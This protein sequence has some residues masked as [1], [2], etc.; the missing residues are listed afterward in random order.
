MTSLKTANRRV[1]SFF[2][3]AALLLATITPGLVPAFASAAQV[4]ERSVELSSASKSNPGTQYKV[5]FTAAASAGAVVVDFCSNSPL[6]GFTCDHPAGFVTGSATTATSGFTL[7]QTTASG[8]DAV[9]LTGAISGATEF[10]VDNITNPSTP[11]SLYVR[12]VTYD[13]EAHAQDYTATNVND[14]GSGAIDQGSAAVSITDTIG[15]SASV[16]ETMTFCVAGNEI[17]AA[18][19]TRTSG[20]L[21]A[22]TVKLGDPSTNALSSQ[23]VSE[24]S[25]Y[26][27]L[28]TNAAG[29]AVVSLKSGNQCG[30]LKRAAT[31]ANVCDIVAANDANGITAN[32]ARF[33]IKVTPGSDPSGATGAFQIT[34]GGSP[35]YSSSVFKL[36]YTSGGASGVTSPFGDPVLDTAAAPANSKNAQITFG[37]SIS[38][39][40]PA[41]LYSNDFSLIATGKF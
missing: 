5:K 14:N 15:V 26:S 2:A 32:Q 17:N 8:D 34:G 33:G 29:G 36:N 3:V 7:S 38:N 13:T 35:F 6:I 10:T 40:T 22:P 28:S 4:T 30:G 25:I 11:G 27:Q 23:A 20:Q 21:T 39:D 18:N 31:A 1:G 16:N 24:G 12:I 9:V 41:G 19:C 37:A